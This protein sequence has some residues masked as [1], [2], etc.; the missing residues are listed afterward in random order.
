MQS[1]GGGGGLGLGQTPSQAMRFRTSST[2]TPP[3]SQAN[4]PAF[5]GKKL[6]AY[7]AGGFTFDGLPEQTQFFFTPRISIELPVLGYAM[8]QNVVD[9]ED[10]VDAP[11][12]EPATSSSSN[13][14]RSSVS[15]WWSNVDPLFFENGLIWSPT[16][17]DLELG[18]VEPTSG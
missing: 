8:I 13:S 17:W 3:Y 5:T 6:Q 10:E 14:S 2:F 11:A 18:L 7:L 1:L 15:P 12:T 9:S 16:D 4:C